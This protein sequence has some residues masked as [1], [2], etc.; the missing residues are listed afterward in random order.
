MIMMVVFRD[1]RDDESDSG[2]GSGDGSGC[3]D[4][5]SSPWWLVVQ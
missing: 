2:G 3:G 4:S 5:G 1:S